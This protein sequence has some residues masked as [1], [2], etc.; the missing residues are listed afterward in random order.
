MNDLKKEKLNDKL[1]KTAC[2]EILLNLVFAGLTLTVAY[3]MVDIKAYNYQK[4]LKNLFG[5]G[6]KSTSLLDVWNSTH[7]F[8]LIKNKY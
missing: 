4:N 5:S 2:K 3:Q 6:E 1:L 7:L 8:L